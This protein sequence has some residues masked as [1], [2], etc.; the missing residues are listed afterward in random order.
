MNQRKL[1]LVTIGA[2]V[3]LAVPAWAQTPSTATS[4]PTAGAASSGQTNQDNLTSYGPAS[5]VTAGI[6]TFG[7][8]TSAG[9]GSSDAVTGEATASATGTA[10]ATGGTQDCASMTAVLGLSPSQM[11]GNCQP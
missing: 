2:I 1:S 8:A 3:A 6:G 11:P 5:P 4:L 10:P 9:R 7:L